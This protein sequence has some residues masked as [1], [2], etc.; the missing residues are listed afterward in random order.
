MRLSNTTLFGL[1]APGRVNPAHSLLGLGAW[2]VGFVSQ[3]TNHERSS[4]KPIYGMTKYWARR[5]S[6]AFRAML[7]AAALPPDASL[8]HEF[9][10]NQQGRHLSHA[11]IVLDP[12]MGGGTTIVEGLRLGYRAIGSDLNPLAWFT[13]LVEVSPVDVAQLQ[14]AYDELRR[15]LAPLALDLFATACPACARSAQSLH[16]FWRRAVR[17]PSTG[18]MVVAKRGVVVGQKRGLLVC[19]LRPARCLACGASQSTGEL[20]SLLGN[21]QGTVVVDE[22]GVV[23][24]GTACGRCR[25]PSLEP[26]SAPVASKV[27]LRVLECN[28]C[29]G[30]Y[31]C[32]SSD[33]VP[34]TCPACGAHIE[35]DCGNCV[36]GKV[37]LPS[38]ADLAF[39]DDAAATGRP[40]YYQLSL[41]EGHCSWCEDENVAWGKGVGYRF[42]KAPDVSDRQRCHDAQQ[43]FLSEQSSLLYPTG[44]V[45]DLEKTNRLVIHNVKRWQDLFLPR[46][47]YCLSKLFTRIQAVEPTAVRRALT[48]AFLGALEHQ[49]VLNL[50]YVPYAQSAS[51][52]GRHDFQ[53][54]AE[55]CEVHAWGTGQGRG[56]F[57]QAFAGVLQGLRYQEDP[58]DRVFDSAG[59][60]K[61]IETGDPLPTNL[62]DSFAELASQTANCL[63]LCQDSRS[64]PTLPDSSVDMVVTDPP[65]ADA[66][67]YAELADYFLAWLSM[68]RLDVPV[69]SS[70]EAPKLGEIV[71]NRSR[72]LTQQNFYAAI[73]QVYRECGRVLKNDGLLAFTFHHTK[74]DQWSELLGALHDAGFVITAAFPVKSEATKSGNLV[75]HSNKA[76]AAYDAVIVCRKTHARERTIGSGEFIDTVVERTQRLMRVLVEVGRVDR[77]PTPSDVAMIAWGQAIALYSQCHA[78]RDNTG[79]WSIEALLDLLEPA[80][81][82][83]SNPVARGQ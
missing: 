54:K 10:Q 7:L 2:D 44:A 31:E 49:N 23:R 34:H 35:D 30:L 68:A 77:D 57:E 82:P 45:S 40:P 70:G 3:L 75:F 78:V 56:T 58:Y 65:Y 15:E 62:A 64:F 12:F 33:W 71:V 73:G 6:T 76:S 8:R 41:I 52:F 83:L 69:D 4:F 72:G 43:A 18:R 16:A 17:D 1:T 39:V 24:R 38:G 11:P 80:I 13:T 46:Q 59:A 20:P 26:T 67:Q 25:A 21:T 42:F 81:G 28:S 79:P 27:P 19:K 63:L 48:A 74:R 53:L 32:L 37:R 29:T 36:D 22:Q 51:G 14:A 61:V 47:L 50:Y 55:A 60:S 5:P 66:V 9:Y